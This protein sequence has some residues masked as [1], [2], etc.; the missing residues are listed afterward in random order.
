MRGGALRSKWN[1]FTAGLGG[2]KTRAQNGT[3][4]DSS[5]SVGTLHFPQ[6]SPN[7]DNFGQWI[8]GWIVAPTSGFYRFWISSDDSSEF[9]LSTN[10]NPANKVSRASVSGWTS[11]GERTKYPSQQSALVH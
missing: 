7:E 3:A 2:L 8:R 11:P 5:A 1:N 4:P 10:K 9:L 6:T